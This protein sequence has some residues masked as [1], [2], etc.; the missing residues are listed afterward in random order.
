MFYIRPS[1]SHNQHTHLLSWFHPIDYF[2]IRVIQS[3]A[4][5]TGLKPQHFSG[6]WNLFPLGVGWA[7]SSK[8]KLWW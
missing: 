7:R 6:I 4:I 5:P 2:G 8:T 3:G 1:S